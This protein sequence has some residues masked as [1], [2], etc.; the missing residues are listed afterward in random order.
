MNLFI[1][2]NWNTKLWEFGLVRHV[3]DTEIM[4]VPPRKSNL[5]SIPEAW[6]VWTCEPCPRHR[7]QGCA[8]QKKPI[9][10]PSLRLG[11]F[12]LACHAQDTEMLVT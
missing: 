11:E 12:G 1:N 8:S 6:G 3:Q 10:L 4:V 2:W 5:F 9:C 7:S